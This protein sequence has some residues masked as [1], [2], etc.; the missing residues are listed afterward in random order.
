MPT[1]DNTQEATLEDFIDS[2]QSPSNEKHFFYKE[3]MRPL[4]HKRDPRDKVTENITK[5]WYKEKA[6]VLLMGWKALLVIAIKYTALLYIIGGITRNETPYTFMARNNRVRY[7]TMAANILTFLP[8]YIFMDFHV[9]EVKNGK[10]PKGVTKIV[11]YLFIGLVLF[12]IE[13]AISVIHFFIQE[14]ILFKAHWPGNFIDIVL[15]FLLIIF[16][17]LTASFHIGSNW[18]KIISK[19]FTNKRTEEVMVSLIYAVSVTVVICIAV[20]IILVLKNSNNIKEL[21]KHTNL[22]NEEKAALSNILDWCGDILNTYS[23]KVGA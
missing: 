9:I 14:K 15:C 22:L 12:G 6:F 19:N 18:G 13:Q 3:G 8:F 16:L 4:I 7:F 23:A 21:L 1:I 10:Y 11:N 17:L 20:A 5:L 2:S